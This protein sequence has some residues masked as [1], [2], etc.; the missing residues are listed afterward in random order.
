MDQGLILGEGLGRTP[1][2]KPN[3][4][5]QVQGMSEHRN[6]KSGKE[7]GSV[8]VRTHVQNRKEVVTAHEIQRSCHT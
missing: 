7:F 3:T 2:T 1:H 4:S 5:Q 8:S 6:Q